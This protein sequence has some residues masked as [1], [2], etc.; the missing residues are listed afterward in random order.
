MERSSTS[1]LI[2]NMKTVY[3]VRHG[4]SEMN[5][6]NRYGTSDTPLSPL[7]RE[8]AKDTA[9]RCVAL[10]ID[11]IISSPIVRARQTA[12]IIRD[13]IEAPLDFSDAFIEGHFTDALDGMKRDDPAAVKIMSTFYGNFGN[14]EF[15]MD[16]GENFEDFKRRG[17]AALAYLESRP[18]EHILVVTHAYFLWILAAA[19]LF[20]SELTPEEC[21][22]VLRGLQLAENTALTVATFDAPLLKGEGEPV[23]KWQLKVWNDHAHLG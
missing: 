12:E 17:L 18:E 5:A 10:P 8:Q 13:H 6:Q 1:R 19:L 23:A 21:L 20:G 9:A 16:G 22:G 15:R 3:F 11:V 4:Q 14:P 2:L 7:G